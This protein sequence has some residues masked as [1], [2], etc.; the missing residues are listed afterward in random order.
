MWM[1]AWVNREQGQPQCLGDCSNS[2][3]LAAVVVKVS[4]EASQDNF[5]PLCTVNEKQVK[6]G[7]NWTE[8]GEESSTD[9][10][11]GSE[12]CWQPWLYLF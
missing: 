3:T 8:E 7:Q 9:C 6:K 10:P 4:W 11:L 1:E 5:Y 12:R 2:P